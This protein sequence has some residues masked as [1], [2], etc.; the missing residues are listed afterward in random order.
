M[1]ENDEFLALDDIDK[2]SSWLDDSPLPQRAQSIIEWMKENNVPGEVVVVQRDE[3]DSNT[4]ILYAMQFSNEV[5]AV[6]CMLT[7]GSMD[8]Y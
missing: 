2:F 1:L 8:Q 5:D 4:G 6:Q 3:L 7:F